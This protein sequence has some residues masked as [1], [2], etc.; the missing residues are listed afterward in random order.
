MSSPGARRF[1]AV[2]LATALGAVSGCLYIPPL[3]PQFSDEQQV[4]IVVGE[5]TRDEVREILGMPQLLDTPALDVYALGR[6]A[7][8]LVFVVAAPYQAAIVPTTLDAERYTVLLHFD[9]RDVVD[10][11]ELEA[12]D[13]AAFGDGVIPVRPGLSMAQLG[14][15]LVCSGEAPGALGT[16]VGVGF[17]AIRFARDGRTIGAG[18]FKLVGGLVSPERIWLC[19]VATGAARTVA[20]P[21]ARQVALS[22]DLD[23]AA[24]IKRSV[25]VVD[26]GSGASVTTY[27]GHGDAHFWTLKGA[28]VAAFSPDGDEIATGGL[29]GHVRVWA[30]T[31]GAERLAVPAHEELLSA[32]AWSPDGRWLASAGRLDYSVRVW[33]AAT[34]LQVAELPGGSDRQAG[35]LAFASDG[36]ALAINLRTHVE[37]WALRDT[38]TDGAPTSRLAFRA[39]FLLP[40][41]ESRDWPF[42]LDIAFSPDG[43]MVAASNGAMVV[44]DL[45]A[46]R[47]TTRVTPAGI[48]LGHNRSHAEALLSLDFSPD[49]TMLATGSNAGVHLW[50]TALLLR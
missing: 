43:R 8:M 24:A 16:R 42:P 4:R 28:V 41:L 39:A 32:L 12:G 45:K 38:G 36:S 11:Y 1:A 15:R 7:G 23:H 2:T 18:G 25:T 50:P 6:S 27:S 30:T 44:F 37:V 22:P 9:A 29:D 40:Q 17:D 48:A 34:G 19:D 3:G 46:G 33:D 49:G 35:A 21:A 14:A 20:L 13:V 26:T 5:T 31:T 10:R 47:V